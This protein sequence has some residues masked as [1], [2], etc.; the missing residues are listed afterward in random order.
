MGISGEDEAEWVIE[1][2]PSDDDRVLH[3][4]A[5]T[6]QTGLMPGIDYAAAVIAQEDAWWAALSDDEAGYVLLRALESASERGAPLHLARCGHHLQSLLSGL[7][8]GDRAWG[9]AL[10]RRMGDLLARGTPSGTAITVTALL[11][12]L[13]A[14]GADPRFAPSPAPLSVG[15]LH[16]LYPHG[17][18]LADLGEALDRTHYPH[19]KPL[20]A[21]PV[22]EVETAEPSAISAQAVAALSE[23]QRAVVVRL[24]QALALETDAPD[25]REQVAWVTG[26]RPVPARYASTLAAA[27]MGGA[28][29]LDGALR[30]TNQR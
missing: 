21:C 2:G 9:I 18:S 29:S 8:A 27:Q 12:H 24:G 11:A 28:V 14:V 20:P 17:V 13:A 3:G 16:R 6:G 4:H 23:A 25:L 30:A 15:L 7:D 19:G 10:L 22:C 5:G 1:P 26:T